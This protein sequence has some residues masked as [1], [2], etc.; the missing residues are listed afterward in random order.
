MVR[1]LEA[2]ATNP[3]IAQ[4]AASMRAGIAYTL[5]FTRGVAPQSKSV[6]QHHD[7]QWLRRPEGKLGT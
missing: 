2:V 5:D 6:A 4:R 7:F 3:A 1:A